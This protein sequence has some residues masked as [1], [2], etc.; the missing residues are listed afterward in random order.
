[1]EDISVEWDGQEGLCKIEADLDYRFADV[2]IVLI[3]DGN[4]S[5]L[6]DRLSL[7][8]KK[9]FRD[10]LEMKKGDIVAIHWRAFNKSQCAQSEMARLRVEEVEGH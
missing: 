7:G 6:S 1:V 4:H 8:S 5:I 3:R 2:R 10:Q 9:E